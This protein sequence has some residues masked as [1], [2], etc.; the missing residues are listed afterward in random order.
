MQRLLVAREACLQME[1]GLARGMEGVSGWACEMVDKIKEHHEG[2][3]AGLRG[4]LLA[5]E[6]ENRRL[7]A[8]SKN[9]KNVSEFIEVKLPE[10][11]GLDYEA[12]KE[13]ARAVVRGVEGQQ[14]QL[15]RELRRALD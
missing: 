3:E 15:F 4:R 10:R 2:E 12:M 13:G 8:A 14:L 6:E 1:G 11:R 7:T 5:L 9:K